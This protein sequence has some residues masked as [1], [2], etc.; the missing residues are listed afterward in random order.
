LIKKNHPA[1]QEHSGNLTGAF[2]PQSAIN[3][4]KVTAFPKYGWGVWY[5]IS[6]PL[7]KNERR[8]KK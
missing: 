2:L 6:V 3:R 1:V 7:I 5:N 4:I 8:L